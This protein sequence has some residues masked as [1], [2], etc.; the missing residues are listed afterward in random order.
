MIDRRALLISVALLALMLGAAA[1]RVALLPDWTHF[2]Y[3]LPDR[4]LVER[5][6]LWLLVAPTCVAIVAGIF[7]RNARRAVASPRAAG[8]WTRWGNTLLIVYSAICT[9]L[10]AFILARSLGLAPAI[11]PTAVGRIGLVL[12]AG[13]LVVSANVMPKL[14]LVQWRSKR[15]LDP[16]RLGQLMRFSARMQVLT[17]IAVMAVAVFVRL[18]VKGTP[19]VFA[20]IA[21]SIL[22]QFVRGWQMRR[23]Q[24][25]EHSGS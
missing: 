17:G 15:N 6:T 13:L 16:A 8:P 4:T 25:R 19:I 1:W 22:V 14:P 5:N 20:I 12:L 10:Q 21:S 18:P 9:L 23:E 11:D 24:A 2:P 3:Y 7:A